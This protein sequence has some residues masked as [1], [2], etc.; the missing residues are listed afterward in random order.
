MFSYLTLTLCE[1][2]SHYKLF[3]LYNYSIHDI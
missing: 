3:V 1:G 2:H